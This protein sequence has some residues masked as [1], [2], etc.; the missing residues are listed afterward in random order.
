MFRA[1]LLNSFCAGDQSCSGIE[2]FQVRDLPLQAFLPEAKNFG[3][4][5]SARLTEWDDADPTPR[6]IRTPQ[7]HKASPLQS[8]CRAI[9]SG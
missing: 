3:G 8:P 4:T 2:N 7:H 6:G 9:T 5:S 1:K